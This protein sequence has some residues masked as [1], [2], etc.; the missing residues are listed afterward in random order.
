MAN[1]PDHRA[2]LAI[3]IHSAIDPDILTITHFG[4]YFAIPKD[5]GRSPYALQF[6]SLP[7]Q[8]EFGHGDRHPK[9]IVFLTDTADPIRGNADLLG[10]TYGR[11]YGLTPAEI[12]VTKLVAAG[13]PLDEAAQQLGISANTLKSHLRQIYLRQDHRG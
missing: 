1:R 4:R 2:A 8:N 12:R 9:A 3:A 6:S 13:Q 10:R 7:V 11:T 5:S